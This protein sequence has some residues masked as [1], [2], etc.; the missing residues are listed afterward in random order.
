MTIAVAYL[1]AFLVPSALVLGLRILFSVPSQRRAPWLI[2]TGAAT[3]FV[4]LVAEGAIW[5][6]VDPHLPS[7]Y[8]TL[9][10]AFVMIAFVEEIAKISLIYG[11]ILNHGAAEFGE[12]AIISAFIA[13]GF[14]GAENVLYVAHHGAGVLIARAITATPF[15]IANAIVT[16]KLLWIAHTTPHRRHVFVVCA[17]GSA[18]ALHGFYDYLVMTDSVRSSKFWFAL[19]MTSGL[20][21]G[22]LRDR[23]A[24]SR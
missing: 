6:V 14:A 2:L 13:A 1:F 24:R 7:E 23:G 20:A 21:V 17:L 16:A 12:V 5:T 15:H 4:A 10:R 22:L 8:A 19:A 9:I 18:T 3:G 11:Q